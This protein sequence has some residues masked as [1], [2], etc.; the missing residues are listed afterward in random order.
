M[1]A[2]YYDRPLLLPRVLRTPE[3]AMPWSIKQTILEP[4]RN[5][6]NEW[7]LCNETVSTTYLFESTRFGKD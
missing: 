6:C 7:A 1:T 3:N 2:L 5:E 4:F